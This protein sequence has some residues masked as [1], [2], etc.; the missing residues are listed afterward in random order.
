M[1]ENLARLRV[2]N[3]NKKK[4]FHIIKKYAHALDGKDPSL[5]ELTRR[6]RNKKFWYLPESLQGTAKQISC[7]LPLALRPSH[8]FI[9]GG[10]DYAYGYGFSSLLL[11]LLLFCFSLLFPFKWEFL[12]PRG[13]EF[14]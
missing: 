13:G 10:Y 6:R 9:S 11:L 14:G 1:R 8:T 7:Y 3:L 2:G 5:K 12:F 4:F